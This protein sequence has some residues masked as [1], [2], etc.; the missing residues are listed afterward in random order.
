MA[1]KTSV[2]KQ[3]LNEPKRM[4]GRHSKKRTSNQKNSK[5]YVKQYKGQGR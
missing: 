4:K 1:K 3:R 2:N 5:L